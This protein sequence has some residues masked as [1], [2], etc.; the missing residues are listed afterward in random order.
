MRCPMTNNLSGRALAEAAAKV[1]GWRVL[2][3]DGDDLVF[4]VRKPPRPDEWEIGGLFVPDKFEQQDHECLEY[5]RER[6]R[7]VRGTE[8]GRAWVRFQNALQRECPRIWDYT[9]GAYARALVAAASP[10]A[11]GEGER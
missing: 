11:A 9:R 4:V 3:R 5:A 2:P 1:M 8:T 6:W 7:D 10:S